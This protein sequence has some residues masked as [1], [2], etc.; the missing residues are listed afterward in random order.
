MPI[1]EFRCERC[2]RIFEALCFTKED[3]KEVKCPFC[4]SREVKKELSSFSTSFGRS[5]GFGG[6]SCGGGSGFG[7]G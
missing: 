2:R 1:Y 6:G 3:E 7:F 4:G 5:F